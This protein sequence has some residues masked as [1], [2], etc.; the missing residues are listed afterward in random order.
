MVVSV[1]IS[2]AIAF[3][4]TV[5]MMHS[6]G[7]SIVSTT[8]TTRED[9]NK[10][11]TCEDY[12]N[13]DLVR[14]CHV[15]PSMKMDCVIWNC[16]ICFWGNDSCY[17]FDVGPRTDCPTQVCILEPKPKPPPG[18]K[19]PIFVYPVLGILCAVLVGVLL[20]LVKLLRENR[21]YRRSRENNV[22][23]FLDAGESFREA[24]RM[25]E[26]SERFLR[27]VAAAANVPY[28]PPDNPEPQNELERL[29]NEPAI[30]VAPSDQVNETQD[31]E[32]NVSHP[33]RRFG[34][35]RRAGENL[36]TNLQSRYRPMR[37][38]WRTRFQL[39]RQSVRSHQF[40]R[41]RNTE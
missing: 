41:F 31:P 28:P 7:N 33:P 16:S 32:E 26:A 3:L 23:R 1:A 17:N 12:D 20:Y 9:P 21:A 24:R 6:D 8:E 37:E 2:V 25:Q 27:E 13:P 5:P 35:L 15:Q 36:A 39:A 18:P 10:N 34:G 40:S 14:I 30:Q 19:P 38:R 4:A 22:R 11:V 29:A